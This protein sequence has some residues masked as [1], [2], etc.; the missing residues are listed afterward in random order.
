MALST[1]D[2]YGIKDGAV[3]IDD[4]GTLAGNLT[5]N[6][7]GKLRLGTGLDLQI[8]HDAAGGNYSYILYYGAALLNIGSDQNIVLG[9]T[10]NENYLIANPDGAVELYYDNSKKLET[11]SVGMRLSGNYQANDGYHI[12]LGTGNDIDLY[13]DGSNTFAL[14]LIHI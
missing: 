14:S 7:S 3:Q 4:I 10:S 11:T 5:I 2:T 12:Y 6:D 1:I 8:W 13:H 9:K